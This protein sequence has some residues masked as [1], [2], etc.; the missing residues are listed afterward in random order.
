MTLR[1]AGQTALSANEKW[2][3]GCDGIG[4]HAQIRRVVQQCMTLHCCAS[5]I[6]FEIVSWPLIFTSSVW[7]QRVL[8][9]HVTCF[10]VILPNLCQKVSAHSGSRS[11]PSLYRQS[12]MDFEPFS[13]AWPNILS[14]AARKS[15]DGIGLAKRHLTSVQGM[16]LLNQ[17]FAA[18]VIISVDC[19]GR[20]NSINSVTGKSTA[21]KWDK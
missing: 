18:V 4:V 21:G 15:F 11:W 5:R 9:F 14:R 1:E 20:G 13:H 2:P 12:I 19:A 3:Q 17:I 16:S 7:S 8:L 10:S 6:S